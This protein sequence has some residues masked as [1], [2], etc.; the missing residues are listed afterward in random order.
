MKNT[1]IVII[2]ILLLVIVFG[3]FAYF[4]NKNA[5]VQTPAT[6]NINEVNTPADT[7]KTSPSPLASVNTTTTVNTSVKEFTVVGQNFSFAPNKISVKKGDT[8]K[9]TFHNNNGMHDLKIDEYN[10]ATKRIAAGTEET[11]TFVADKAGSFV[12]YCSVGNHRAQGM[13]GTLTVE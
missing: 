8:V 4:K 10:V 7:T 3:G 12:Y 5:E 11:V 6:L 2:V 9:I 1:N 13:W